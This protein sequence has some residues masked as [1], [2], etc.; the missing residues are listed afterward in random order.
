MKTTITEVAITLEGK[1]PIY[2]SM[3]VRVM[4]EAAGSFLK[5][6]GENEGNDGNYLFIEWEEWDA[7]VEVVAKYREQWEWDEGGE[8]L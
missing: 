1:N 6:I 7:I 8:K 5:L 2:E 4:D 3:V